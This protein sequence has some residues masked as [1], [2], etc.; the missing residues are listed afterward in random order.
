M[1]QELEPLRNLKSLQK[2][3]FNKTVISSLA[4]LEK[5]ENLYLLFN[6]TKI[7]F[8]EIEQFKITHPNSTLLTTF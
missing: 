5:M 1:N 2:I 8:D 3:V 4:P 7:S 6:N